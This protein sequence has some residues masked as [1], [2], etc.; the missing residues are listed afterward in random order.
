MVAL[1]SA[2]QASA[3][4]LGAHPRLFRIDATQ[5]QAMRA[6]YGCCLR[7]PLA[8]AAQSME[9]HCAPVRAETVQL[10][11]SLRSAGLGFEVQVV[12]INGLLNDGPLLDVAIP[13]ALLQA[14][15]LHAAAPLWRALEAW[16]GTPVELLHVRVGGAA[17]PAGQTL[18]ARLTLLHSN[19]APGG[20]ASLLLRA[21]HASGW[22]ALAAARRR[23]A[24][25][26]AWNA[27]RMDCAVYAA[28]VSL[29]LAELAR[30]ERDDIVLLGASLPGGALA[31]RLGLVSGRDSATADLFGVPLQF[32][33]QARHIRVC[34]QAPTLSPSPISSKRRH[35]MTPPATPEAVAATA[36]AAAM[37]AQAPVGAASARAGS[38]SGL[39][40][41][42]V[43]VLVELGRLT[44]P[45]ATLQSL[46]VGQVFATQQAIDGDGV[47]LWCGGQQLALGQLVAVGDQIGVRIVTV[48]HAAPAAATTAASES[49]A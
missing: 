9:I 34:A 12:E 38:E 42:R 26:E 3:R 19:P 1:L 17:W 21:Q 45:L 41:V 15:L 48:P 25:S 14:A 31:A 39:E 32:E 49:A 8:D 46:S 2:S 5:A 23:G 7:V 10:E 28:P 43:D 11:L 37:N 44:L 4:P 33:P 13:Q 29:R 18:G 6:W 24:P 36:A 27:L 35:A 40:G 16:L 22:L 30:L 20:Q 47:V